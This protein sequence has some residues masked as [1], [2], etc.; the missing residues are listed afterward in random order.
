MVEMEVKKRTSMSV[1]VSF[2]N[3]KKASNRDTETLHGYEQEEPD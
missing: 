1:L 2:H 3:L